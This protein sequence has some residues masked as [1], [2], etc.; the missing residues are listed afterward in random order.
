[1]GRVS[2]GPTLDTRGN[3]GVDLGGAFGYH[4]RDRQDG[5]AS[6]SVTYA[7]ATAGLGGDARRPVYSVGAGAEWPAIDD[8]DT[9]GVRVLLGVALR[10]SGMGG[11]GALVGLDVAALRVVRSSDDRATLLG[12]GLGCALVGGT[13]PPASPNYG[14]FRLDLSAEELVDNSAA[15]P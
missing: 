2:A 5:G 6:P 10:T 4:S 9:W 11:T 8:D 3:L 15:G 7:S 14:L 1:M 12:V 13:N